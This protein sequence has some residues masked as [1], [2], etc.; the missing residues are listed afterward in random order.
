M[1]KLNT[2]DKCNK[3]GAH[4]RCRQIEMNKINR[5]EHANAA[6]EM[7]VFEHRAMDGNG[8]YHLWLKNL[9]NNAKKSSRWRMNRKN[10]QQSYAKRQR[11]KQGNAKFKRRSNRHRMLS[12][13]LKKGNM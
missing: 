10:K 4:Q 8:G 12:M 7:N 13:M 11:D 5:K 1:G 3:N 2:C 9:N 6:Y